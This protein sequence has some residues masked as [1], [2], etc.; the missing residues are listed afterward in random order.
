MAGSITGA[1]RHNPLRIV[2]RS[3]RALVATRLNIAKNNNVQGECHVV[4]HEL[5][6]DAVANPLVARAVP[7]DRLTR[8]GLSFTQL[9][10]PNDVDAGRRL[11]RCTEVI[12]LDETVENI[13][14]GEPANAFEDA[15]AQ[16]KTALEA[17]QGKS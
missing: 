8:R 13:T 14:R 4:F 9:V 6:A 2:P 12:V 11:N 7:T 10:A 3:H 15:A 1:P 17:G 16:V 5:R